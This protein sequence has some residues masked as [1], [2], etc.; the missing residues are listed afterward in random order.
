MPLLSSDTLRRIDESSLRNYSIGNTGLIRK[1]K[2]KV[3]IFCKAQ[4]FIFVT[5]ER[6][7]NPKDS[8]QPK[9]TKYTIC[10]FRTSIS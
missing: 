4:N 1:S 10:T 7:R 8:N 6:E 3:K 2:L 5:R 9:Q